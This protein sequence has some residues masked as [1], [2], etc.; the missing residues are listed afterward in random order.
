MTLKKIVASCFFL[1][2]SLTSI[3]A[4]DRG[5]TV[6]AQELTG[7]TEFDIGR[8]Y[9][10]IIGID[11]YK[12][13]PALKGAVAEGRAV[14][15]AL[16][17]RYYIDGFFE[18][19]NEEATASGIR[20]LFYDKLPAVL[21]PK[22]SLLIFYA[23]H[24]SLDKYDTGFWIA[25]DGSKDY[26]SQNNW[27]ANSQLRNMVGGLNVQRILVVADSCFSG[28]FV[29]LSRGDL[30]KID[31][32]YQARALQLVA[33]QVLSAGSSET[34]PDDSEFGHQFVQLLERN[35]EPILDPI[36]MYD[37]IR[38]GVTK[39]LPLL[40]S[41]PGNQEGASYCLFLRTEAPG[42]NISQPDQRSGSALE[43]TNYVSAT[44]LPKD[45]MPKEPSRTDLIGQILNNEFPLDIYI[46]IPILVEDYGYTVHGLSIAASKGLS[47]W[48]SFSTQLLFQQNLR[49]RK[50][51]YY[52]SGEEFYTEI[53][54]DNM[55]SITSGGTFFIRMKYFTEAFCGIKLG[56][57][58]CNGSFKSDNK[59]NTTEKNNIEYSTAG[60][61]LGSELGFNFLLTKSIFITIQGEFT[62]TI[63]DYG[64]EQLGLFIGAGYRM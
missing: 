31:K 44:I 54:I 2:F 61:S 37:Y 55:F 1:I 22:D 51:L 62:A 12:E 6:I 8:Q 25:S 4:Q 34:V 32:A 36:R 39:T 20:A 19:Y 43:S 33:R 28:D 21:G 64:W 50:I 30:P 24:G 15:K 41:L 46:K 29:N 23:G 56:L 13:W 3:S 58:L 16:S 9:A 38:R 18:L 42:Y 49:E 26:L 27:I 63:E 45:A 17:E 40:G 60:L 5:L 53:N 10:V 52:T 35:D 7:K 14:R 11:R 57:G 48:L 47:K 59:N